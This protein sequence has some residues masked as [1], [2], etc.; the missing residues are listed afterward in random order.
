LVSVF[1]LFNGVSKIFSFGQKS[2]F[3]AAAE[4]PPPDRYP[5]WCMFLLGLLEV[6]AA[7]VLITPATSALIAAIFLAL[8]TAASVVFRL[9]RHQSAAPTIA[10]FLMVLFV[11]L[12]RWF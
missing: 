9:R 7:L 12:G 11:I 10:L 1:F 2:S 8:L 4:I 6:A 3:I 5:Y